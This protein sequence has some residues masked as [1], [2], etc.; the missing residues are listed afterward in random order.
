MLDTRLHRPVLNP[1][2]QSPWASQDAIV[3]ATG[4]PLRSISDIEVKT[5][6]QLPRLPGQLFAK[7]GSPHNATDLAALNLEFARNVIVF[8]N[9]CAD[10]HGIPEVAADFEAI[11]TFFALKKHMPSSK[12]LIELRSASHVRFLAQDS[13][14]CMASF[15]QQQAEQF[16]AESIPQLNLADGNVY[17]RG[18]LDALLAQ[19]FFNPHA[20]SLMKALVLGT[21][22]PRKKVAALADL[23]LADGSLLCHFSNPLFLVMHLSDSNDQ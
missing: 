1:S 23:E 13:T 18:S 3:D 11:A 2:P 4:A 8:S 9:H 5:N 19:S 10:R 16:G 14:S 15:K 12:V 22:H 20:Q 21:F 6:E 17:V 7:W